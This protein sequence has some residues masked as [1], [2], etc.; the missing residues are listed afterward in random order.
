MAPDKSLCVHGRDPLACSESC[1][2][3]LLPRGISGDKHNRLCPCHDDREASL[4]INPGTKGMRIIWCCGAGCSFEDV[5]AALESRGADP[6]C[7]GRYGLPKRPVVPG[8]RIQY[9][10]PATV[11]DAKRFQAIAKLPR[12]L[13]GKL[14]VM[15]VQA[16]IEGD[17]DLPADPLVLLGV[18]SD[19]F[20][21]LAD[22]AGIDAKYKYR[23]FKH[24]M[25]NAV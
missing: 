22:R 24:W 19:D 18:N 1:L 8:M 11:A 13:N 14:Y 12:S 17:G 2:A 25:T 5:R 16:I 6:S 3:P 20:Y 4:S 7:L 9:A 23:L 21:G 10:D 15:C